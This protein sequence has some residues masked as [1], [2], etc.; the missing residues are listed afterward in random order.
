M[1]TEHTESD[2]HYLSPVTSS[3]STCLLDLVEEQHECE[4]EKDEEVKQELAEGVV[5]CNENGMEPIKLLF[6]PNP[7]TRLSISCFR[8]VKIA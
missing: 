7:P 5:N 2:M 3:S 1:D 4:L 8:Y 6:N